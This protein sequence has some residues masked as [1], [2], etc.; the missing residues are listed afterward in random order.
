[1]FVFINPFQEERKANGRLV[2]VILAALVIFCAIYQA[3]I[4]K[5]GILAGVLVP[6]VI[7]LSFAGW[8]VVL[9]KRDKAK[10]AIFVSKHVVSFL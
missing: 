2:A 7:M 8:V 5:S 1:M 9:A 4:R 10:R 3:W 6:A